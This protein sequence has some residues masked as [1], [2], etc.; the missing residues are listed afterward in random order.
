MD[1]ANTER[2]GVTVIGSRIDALDWRGCVGLI[3]SWAARRESRYVCL[4]NVHSIVT[5]RRDAGFRR[6]IEAADLALPDGAPVAWAMRRA[7]RRGQQRLDGPQLMWRCCARAARDGLP[8]FLYGA[9]AHT[10]ARLSEAL[11]RRFPALRLAGCCAPPFRTLTDEEDAAVVRAI[12]ESGA[13]IV[14][15]ALGCPKQE[16][17]MA[18]HR[19]R[20]RA[21]MIGVGAAFD[22]H[23]GTAR[24]APRWMR[25]AGLEWAHRLAREPRRLWRR[26]LVTNT[27]FLAYLA[28]DR[29]AR[30][31]EDRR[32]PGGSRRESPVSTQPGRR[33]L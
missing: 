6:V 19:E 32:P 20:V 33:G 9:D 24:R 30:R 1:T 31:R 13:H 2:Q 29:A 8:V 11:T 12:A 23:A 27:L 16:A 15:V 4:C 3:A 21:V 7:G 17:W 28:L 10:L 14:L 22:Y 26:Y 25:T 5:A 18:A